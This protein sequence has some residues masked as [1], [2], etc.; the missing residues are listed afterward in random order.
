M[1][2]TG[3]SHPR[4]SGGPAGPGAPPGTPGLTADEEKASDAQGCV[5]TTH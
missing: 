5:D 3:A 4:V 1:N 2:C